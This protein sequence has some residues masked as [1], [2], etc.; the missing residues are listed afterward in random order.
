M[1]SWATMW[2]PRPITQRSPIRSS[3]TGPSS[4]PGT[5]PADIDT[6]LPRTVSV[7]ICDPGLTEDGPRREDE[8]R[9]GPERREPRPGR[10]AGG[11]RARAL[12]R[13]PGPVDGRWL[14]ARQDRPVTARLPEL[15]ITSWPN[16]PVRTILLSEEPS[17]R[18]V[19]RARTASAY[20]PSEPGLVPGEWPV[21]SAMYHCGAR[22][23]AGGSGGRPP[24]SAQPRAVRRR[25]R[26]RGPG[27]PGR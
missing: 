8:D 27:C 16:Q 4:W 15:T 17:R 19:Y 23:A 20:R 24:G 26:F 11:D 25:R 13:A 7:P 3:G 6:C 1:E 5:V 18:E 12:G 2:V 10:G 14:R 22:S 21:C 9:A